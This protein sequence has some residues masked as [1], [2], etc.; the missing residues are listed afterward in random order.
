MTAREFFFKYNTRY[1]DFDGQFGAQ[2]KD[3]FN[4]YNKEVVGAPR[5]YGHAKDLWTSTTALKYYHRIPN[6]WTFV[7]REGD[8][9]V[10]P[11]WSANPY[12]HVAI[13]SH[14]NL[15]WFVSF[16]Q[17]WPLGTPCHFQTHNYTYPRV[18]GVLRPKV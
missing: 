7:P 14:G 18:Y 6:T 16:D 17:N 2:C 4:F 10:W 15:L 8:V 5:I 12:G 1:L 13:V 3:L 9:M 11:A